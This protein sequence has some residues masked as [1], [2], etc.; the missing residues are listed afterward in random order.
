MGL[1]LEE[2][3]LPE[4]PAAEVA[5]VIIT[6]EALS[7]FERFHRDGSIERLHDPY[8]PYQWEINRATTGDDLVKAWRMRQAF[9]K[10]S[11]VIARLISG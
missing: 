8:A 5:S 2:A 3:K 11:P 7:A 10:S 1:K 9:T 6:S 4:F